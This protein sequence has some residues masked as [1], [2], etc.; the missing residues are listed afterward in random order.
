MT[1]SSNF[2][3]DRALIQVAVI[4]IELNNRPS[5]RMASL[6]DDQSRRSRHSKSQSTSAL[7]TILDLPRSRESI[8]PVPRIPYSLKSTTSTPRAGNTSSRASGRLATVPGLVDSS[9]L[10][11][12]DSCTTNSCESPTNSRVSYSSVQRSR[13]YRSLADP[14]SPTPTR[15]RVKTTVINDHDGSSSPLP[16]N[17]PPTS[18]STKHSNKDRTD[19]LKGLGVQRRSSKRRTEP[20]SPRKDL[21]GSRTVSGGSS[22]AEK[23]ISLRDEIDSCVRVV[24]AA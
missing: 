10:S 20:R 16:L 12:G 17:T 7:S 9:D 23:Q 8:P 5:L 1:G 13:T 11:D 14:G 24:S 6:S 18:P 19:G 2:Q 21:L 4:Q 3:P 22:R 15:T